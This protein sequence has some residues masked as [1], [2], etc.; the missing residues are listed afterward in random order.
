MD[1]RVRTALVLVFLFGVA[2]VAEPATA[3]LAPGVAERPPE[4]CERQSVTVDRVAPVTITG[5]GDTAEPQPGTEPGRFTGAAA[6]DVATHG[7]PTVNVSYTYRRLPDQEGVVEVSMRLPATPGLGSVGFEFRE[8][9]VT[10]TENVATNG[11]T[12]EWDGDRDAEIVYRLPINWSKVGNRRG[13]WTLLEHRSPSTTAD[14]DFRTNIRITGDGYAGNK[15]LVLGSHEVY[16]RQVAGQTIDLVVPGN[17]SL[18]Y[19]PRRTVAALANASRAQGF[20]ARAPV[21]TA[22]ATPDIRE[23]V[24]QGTTYGIEFN[25]TILVD[26]DT[27]L[28]VW[29]HEYVHTSQYFPRPEGLRW[30]AEGSAQYYE[31]VLTVRSGYGPWAAFQRT[32]DRGADDDSVLAAPDTWQ[33]GPRYQ[34]GALVL[35][36]IDREIRTATNGS[37]T[38]GDVFGRAN[39]WGPNATLE[40]FFGAVRDVGGSNAAAT[41]ERYLTT[42]ATPDPT[43]FKPVYGA[44]YQQ[45]ERQV[46]EAVAVGQDRNR[47]LE[48]LGRNPLRLG[49][50]V[51]ITARITNNGSARG[52]ARLAPNLDTNTSIIDEPWV[53]WLRP[54]ETVTRTV[55]HQFDSPGRYEIRGDTF[56]GGTFTYRFRVAPE[57]DTASVT[58]L[59]VTTDDTDRIGVSTT[60]RNTGDRDTFVAL[61]VRLDGRRVST[62]T[63]VV[64][65]NSVRT[66]FFTVNRSGAGTIAVGDAETAI[67]SSTGTGPTPGDSTA[68]PG[69]VTRTADSGTGPGSATPNPGDESRPFA[70]GPAVGFLA[71]LVILGVAGIAARRLRER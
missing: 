31:E 26:A 9:T 16:R 58:G 12:Y 24:P 27:E 44:G 70:T 50:T 21:V 69:G 7:Q 19:G 35:A 33:V 64:G 63:L 18:L 25:R 52:L 5:P 29:V 37:R 46:L 23:P 36:A 6:P 55:S 14:V 61:P 1:S 59:T 60:V 43:G 54:N 51:R 65:S 2:A 39:Q 8:G 13:S 32:L 22:F 48:R 20:E 3:G 57:R 4:R 71:V 28:G 53:G 11:S 66:V 30:L 67:G 56:E 15:A 40:T 49:E 38:I 41:A 68:S 47:T 45:L 62:T 42:S 34:K 10:G 17:V